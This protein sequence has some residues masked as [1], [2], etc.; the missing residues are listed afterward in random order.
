MGFTLLE[1]LFTLLVLSAGLVPILGMHMTALHKT[2]EAYLN[3]VA[4]AQ[5][6]AMLE[7]LRVNQSSQ[8]QNRELLYWNQINAN[9]LP[10]GHGDYHCARQ[11]CVVQLQWYMQTIH[12]LSLQG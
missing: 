5:L 3:S 2:Q 10:S 11:Y 8:A 1:V 7:R 9:L 12:H 4:A 6:A